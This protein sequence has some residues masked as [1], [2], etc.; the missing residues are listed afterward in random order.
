M[1]EKLL[2]GTLSLNTTNQILNTV[3]LVY[4]EFSMRQ[5][6]YASLE[7]FCLERI[8]Q[9]LHVLSQHSRLPPNTACAELDSGLI[10]K[11]LWSA[12]ITRS[13]PPLYIS[14]T[15]LC[16]CLW[17]VV[18]RKVYFDHVA[19]DR[20][21]QDGFVQSR[22]M[23]GRVVKDGVIFDEWI[24]IGQIVQKRVVQNPVVQG[25]MLQAAV[26]KSLHRTELW[27]VHLSE[28]SFPNT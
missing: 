14:K 23:Q 10:E 26:A 2:T 17:A 18:L 6:D 3:W 20:V 19:K 22:V 9:D 8:I 11:S 7:H 27:K 21:V 24:I 16:R 25:L 15:F 5:A 12:F 1:T 4:C 13:E 28:H